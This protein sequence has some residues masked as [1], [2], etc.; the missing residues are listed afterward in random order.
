MGSRYPN[1]RGGFTKILRG[2][3]AETE[4]KVKRREVLCERLQPS[5]SRA[6]DADCV[7]DGLALLCA[8]LRAVREVVQERAARGGQLLQIAVRGCGLPCV[9]VPVILKH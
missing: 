8:E 6:Q 5:E 1:A 2:E 3:S 9:R 4:R 7:A